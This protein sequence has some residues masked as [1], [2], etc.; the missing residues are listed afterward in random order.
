MKKGKSMLSKMN[1]INEVGAY[2]NTI[3]QLYKSSILNR[4]GK[5]TN[6]ELFTEVIAEELLR[7]DIKNR[8]K[9]INEVVRE[10][11]YRVITH[12]GVVTTGHK[13]EDSNR[14]EERVAIQLFNLSQSG[15]IF[16]GI[17]RI[18][19]YQVPLKNSSA[20][21]GLGK[22]DLIS[23][24]DDCMVLIEFKINENRET[25]LRCVLEIATYYQ[26]LSKS[27]F[28]NSYSNEFGSPK[29]I[30]KAVLIVIDSLHY[31][32]MLELRNGERRH[33][34]KL[35]DTLEVQVFCMDPVSFEVQT[36]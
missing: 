29:R 28:L 30:K 19:D 18:M 31:K 33:L 32:E 26:V 20:D 14:K 10:S 8:L 9:E 3:D 23:L 15:K 35:M 5:T 6:G 4:R 16:N 7:L 25:L 17:G 2:V 11:G 21:K 22:I 1:L 36:L 27:K 12:D 13:E 34:E 24:V